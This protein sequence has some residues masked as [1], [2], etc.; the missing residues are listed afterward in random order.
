MKL[1]DTLRSTAK[2]LLSPVPAKP[3]RRPDREGDVL[4]VL[5]NGP[6]LADTI[7]ESAGTL[8]R[9]PLMAVNFAAN[10]PEYAALRPRYYVLADPHFFRNLS[11]VNVSALIRNLDSQTKWPLTLFAPDS[12]RRYVPAFSNQNIKTE[13]FKMTAVEG[14]R[15]FEHLA[16]AAGLGMPRPRNVLIPALMTGIALGFK[17]IYIVGADHGWTRTLSV[18]DRNEVISIQ[19]HYY[20]EDS[21]EKRRIRTEYLRYPL[22]KILESFM[23]AFRSYHTIERYARSRGVEIVNS[24]PGSFIDAFTRRPLP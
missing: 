18:N 8:R 5:G 14:Y 2:I 22:H 20:E 13:Y 19:P 9:Y 16:F 4:I 24:T 21:N 15:T 10:T 11:D 23:V 17:T 3:S 6:S 7:A 1:T 12:A